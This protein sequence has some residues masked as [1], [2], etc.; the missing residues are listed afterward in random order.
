MNIGVLQIK[1]PVVPQILTPGVCACV[2]EKSV[3]NMQRYS[4][5]LINWQKKISSKSS[6]NLF[7]S[8]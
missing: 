8:S 4:S 2:W 6:D 3:D 5:Q 7:I 1:I